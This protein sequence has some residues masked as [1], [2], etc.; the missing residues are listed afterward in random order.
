[1]KTKFL[2]LLLAG[3]SHVYGQ[4][5]ECIRMASRLDSLVKLSEYDKAYD[6]WKLSGKC[7]SEPILQSGEKILT[8]KL[9]TPIDAVEKMGLTAELMD[10]YAVYDKR[11][12]GNK[13]SNLV[14]KA[15]FFKNDKSVP[16]NDIYNLLDTAFKNDR[17]N[18][19]DAAALQLYFDLYF[20]KFKSGDKAVSENE[21]FARHDDVSM[22]LSELAKT[23]GKREYETARNGIHALMAPVATCDKLE[24]Y[25]EKQFESHR[26][27]AL[28]MQKACENL[29]S[30]KCIK[31]Q[32]LY[33]IASEWQS[34][35]PNSLSALYLA[36]A[37]S[38]RGK[39]A[40]AAKYY[41]IAADS[42][43][44]PLQKAEIYYTLAIGHVTDTPKAI[45]Y[46]EKA[47]KAKPD[48]GR[49][50]LL[51]A[52]MYAS[53]GC[54]NTPFEQ[55]AIYFLAA[56]TARKAGEV[57]KT[58]KKAAESTASAMLAKAPSKAEIKEA[59]KAGKTITYG[60]G[61]NESVTLPD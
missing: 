53:S 34:S 26:G 36:K 31:S 25:Y 13:N 12:P 20:A 1:M 10:L 61:I 3:L 29:I 52:E 9:S 51:K 47:L 15:M 14:K 2:L 35:S 16:E 44:N 50:Y 43:T 4:E 17:A 60:C 32:V 57:D 45:E 30:S 18:F 49:A 37:L 58:M 40:E 55:K 38:F 23:T 11:F 41:A 27:D 56:Q 21:L 59:K 19:T 5:K 8:Y 54:G 22:Q 46:L 24:A 28:W 7:G 39:Q 48:F 42:E 33:K 6:Q